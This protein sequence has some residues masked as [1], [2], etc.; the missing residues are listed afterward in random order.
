MRRLLTLSFG[1]WIARGNDS[2]EGW[3]YLPV[4]IHMHEAKFF[5]RGF[6][7]NLARVNSKDYATLN[8]DL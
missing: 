3:L 6:P 2:S 1:R 4:E 7:N 5:A 8:I